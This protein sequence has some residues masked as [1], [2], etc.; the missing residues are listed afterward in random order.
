MLCCA[1]TTTR[2]LYTKCNNNN[3]NK[4]P[5][6]RSSAPLASHTGKVKNKQTE[7]ENLT[8][9][10]IYLR[11][12]F[13]CSYPMRLCVSLCLF[14]GA[15]VRGRQTKLKYIYRYVLHFALVCL[16]A[17]IYGLLIPLLFCSIN[18]F[19][20]GFFLYTIFSLGIESTEKKIISFFPVYDLY[21][22]FGVCVCV[23]S[24][25][26]KEYLFH[27]QRA[28]VRSDPHCVP[29]RVYVLLYLYMYIWNNILF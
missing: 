29:W 15:F 26:Q 7:K 1:I 16:L 27:V 21:S 9:D 4:T 6:A 24:F 20:F 25:I 2:C 18:L 22:L 10:L 5:Q 13:F 17:R 28:R 23:L 19:W 8:I 3:D 14:Y 12:C 11:C